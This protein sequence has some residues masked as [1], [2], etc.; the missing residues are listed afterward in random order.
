MRRIDCPCGHQADTDEVLV[1]QAHEH[2]EHHHPELE[3]SDEEL[4]EGVSRGAYDV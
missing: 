4:G 2:I 3:R 1:R